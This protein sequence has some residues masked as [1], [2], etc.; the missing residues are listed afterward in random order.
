MRR[1]DEFL[2]QRLAGRDQQAAAAVQV[3]VEHGLGPSPRSAVVDAARRLVENRGEGPT[4][5]GGRWAHGA[6]SQAAM[7]STSTTSPRAWVKGSGHGRTG[8]NSTSAP[9]SPASSARR[10][11]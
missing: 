3:P 7:L 1:G 11:W 10:R 9:W 4:T 6:T 8:T 2:T 5:I